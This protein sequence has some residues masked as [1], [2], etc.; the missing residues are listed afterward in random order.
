MLLFIAMFVFLAAAEERNLVQT[1][2]SLAGVRVR[3]AMLTDFHTLGVH[4][5]LQRAVDYLMAGSQQDFPVVNGEE[6]VGILTRADLI[7]ALQ[8]HGVE[9]SVGDAVRPDGQFAHPTDLL[10]DVMMRMRSRNRTAMPVLDRGRLVGL[11]TLENVGDLLLVRDA[12]KKYAA[13]A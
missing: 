7:G 13:S 12:L 8:A 1:R 4:D 10:E 9:A 2:A 3:E 6:P 5:P 11:I